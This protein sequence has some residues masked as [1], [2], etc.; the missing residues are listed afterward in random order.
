[1]STR[2]VAGDRSFIAS[3]EKNFDYD[4]I[5]ENLASPNSSDEYSSDSEDEAKFLADASP[6]SSV[7]SESDS[8]YELKFLADA[9][10]N[11]FTNDQH[12]IVPNIKTNSM[13]S[14]S[15]S[16]AIDPLS[17][18]YQDLQ[19]SKQV[20]MGI[21]EDGK[22]FVSVFDFINFVSGKSLKDSYGQ[23]TYDRYTSVGSKYFDELAKL[24]FMHKFTNRETPCL[25]ITG[26]FF[27]HIFDTFSHMYFWSDFSR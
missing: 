1:L 9:S 25:N 13:Q 12:T 15:A 24:T 6:N 3:I 27:F 26:I 5:V 18:L 4:D 17:K 20:R 8:E 11:I 23:K 14:I 16:N 19:S 22:P 21:G 7:E 2:F 10:P